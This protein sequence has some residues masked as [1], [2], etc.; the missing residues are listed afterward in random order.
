MSEHLERY[1]GDW[2]CLSCDTY[3]PPDSVTEK[4]CCSYCG[5]PLIWH[6]AKIVIDNYLLEL[7][8]T[9]TKNELNISNERCS[10][11]EDQILK[12]CDSCAEYKTETA[13]LKARIEELEKKLGPL[14]E[15]QS[16]VSAEFRSIAYRSPAT[17]AHYTDFR[18]IGS[19]REILRTWAKAT[20]KA[21]R[22]QSEQG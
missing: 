17:T 10:V 8:L 13:K 20:A 1:K 22:G 2:F 16:Q 15:M 19:L 21:K 7:D 5:T 3:I 6:P 18:A 12:P 4:E 9:K 14:E 11:L